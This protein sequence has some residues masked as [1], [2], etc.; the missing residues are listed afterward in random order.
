MNVNT[1]VKHVMSTGFGK[2]YNQSPVLLNA[3]KGF[4]P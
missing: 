4:F 2:N 1:P 3:I